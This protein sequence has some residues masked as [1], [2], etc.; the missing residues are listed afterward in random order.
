MENA[1]KVN[2]FT[3]ITV[4]V[5]CGV[6]ALINFGSLSVTAAKAEAPVPEAR[7]CAEGEAR[8]L[9]EGD[10][11]SYDGQGGIVGASYDVY[12][13]YKT[14]V[15]DVF[16]NG[17]SSMTNTCA[18]VAGA[19]I[20][21][22]YDRWST[23]LI[24]NF[25]PGLMLSGKYVYYPDMSYEP[26]TNTIASLYNLMQTNVNGGGTSESEFMSGLTTYVTNA[27]YNLSYTSFH[28]N[29]TMVDL[30]KL[31]TAIN[32]G[33]VGLVMCSK[34]NFVYDIIHYDDHTRVVKENGDAGHMM[35][36]YGY[37]TIAYYKNGVNFQTNT[38]LYT[39]SGYSSSDMGYMQLNDYSQINNAM[40][41]TI[42]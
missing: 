10:E 1:H 11:P 3:K 8:Y 26:V 39:C 13:D 18:P 19:N 7:Y 16:G 35:M 2:F 33:K 36:V 15:E 28:Q 12:Y 32:A 41:M 17:D 24:P 30:P 22:Y 21:G 29:A 23:N 4:P 20:V 25:E 40:V 5:L 38:F 42:A 9:D 37:Q 6:L 27:G 34:Y 31:K 14:I